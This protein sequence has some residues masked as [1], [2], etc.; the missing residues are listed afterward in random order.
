M[1]KLKLYQMEIVN[2]G[3]S[4]RDCYLSPILAAVFVNTLYFEI[5]VNK[6]IECWKSDE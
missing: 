2:G 5:F 4:P 3:L 6:S 1:K